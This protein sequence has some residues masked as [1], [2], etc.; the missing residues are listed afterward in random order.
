[1]NIK[2][3]NE[4][5]SKLLEEQLYAEGVITI[6]HIINDDEVLYIMTSDS[7]DG[8]YEHKS[9]TFVDRGW[10]IAEFIDNCILNPIGETLEDGNYEFEY[11]RLG[12][13]NK[14]SYEVYKK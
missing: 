6:D 12:S 8:K 11:K 14:F 10:L 7:V 4:K 13:N 2:Q 1:M 9:T 5:L 3:L